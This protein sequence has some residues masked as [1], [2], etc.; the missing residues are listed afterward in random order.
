MQQCYP[1]DR[2]GEAVQVTVCTRVVVRTVGLLK[3]CCTR[4]G[5][6][7]HVCVTSALGDSEWSVTRAGFFV[8]GRDFGLEDVRI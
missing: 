7:V 4:T 2:E 1:F 5:G 8:T 6:G 3:H